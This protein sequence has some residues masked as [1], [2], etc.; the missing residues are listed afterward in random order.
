MEFHF[1]MVYRSATV[2]LC[3]DVFDIRTPVGRFRLVSVK[4]VQ[5][6][7]SFPLSQL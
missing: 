4:R 3:I 5:D 6:T 2:G 1:H 7:V